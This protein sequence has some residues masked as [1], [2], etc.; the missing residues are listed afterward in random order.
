MTY[1]N[2]SRGCQFNWRNI[3]SV[4]I[5][6]LILGCEKFSFRRSCYNDFVIS[7]GFIVI[8]QKFTHVQAV[9]YAYCHLH[10]TASHT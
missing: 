8:S 5:H 3:Y 1:L 7:C 4:N 9:A 10:C 2:K 6:G